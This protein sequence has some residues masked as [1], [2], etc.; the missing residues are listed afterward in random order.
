MQQIVLISEK[1]KKVR[2]STGGTQTHQQ[3][4]ILKHKPDNSIEH[5]LSGEAL[6]ISKSLP[7]STGRL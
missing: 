2:Q 7:R 6:R 4:T 5:S 1:Q 3:Y